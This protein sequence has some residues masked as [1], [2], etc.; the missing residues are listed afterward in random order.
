MKS[1]NSTQIDFISKSSLLILITRS[2]LNNPI[3]NKLLKYK[4]S[5]RNRDQSSNNNN[6]SNEVVI[7]LDYYKKQELL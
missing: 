2:N 3:N 1:V 4:Y 5:S 6:D 7:P